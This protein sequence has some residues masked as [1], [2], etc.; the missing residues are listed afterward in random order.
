MK[1]RHVTTR[2]ALENIMLSQRSQ[3]QKTSCCVTPFIAQLQFTWACLAE[4]HQLLS[5]THSFAG[6]FQKHFADHNLV[7]AHVLFNPLIINA[8]LTSC[9]IS[10]WFILLLLLF[11]FFLCTAFDFF[12]FLKECKIRCQ[13]A[14]SYAIWVWS[15]MEFTPDEPE[16]RDGSQFPKA[17]SCPPPS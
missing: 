7:I 15:E 10:P 11:S 12:F 3:I 5:L 17:S 2:M 1:K 16:V 8:R 14:L 6:T 13:Q 9:P 4:Q